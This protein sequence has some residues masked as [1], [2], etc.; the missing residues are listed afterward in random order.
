MASALLP[1][2]VSAHLMYSNE[3]ESMVGSGDGMCVGCGVGSEVGFGVGKRVGIIV[4]FA[5]GK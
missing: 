1:C 2:T 5:L 3:Q 4:G